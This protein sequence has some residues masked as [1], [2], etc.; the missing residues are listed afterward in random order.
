[1]SEKIS[2]WEKI[3]EPKMY[4][5]LIE[6]GDSKKSINRYQRN[7]WI[8]TIFI[9]LFGLTVGYFVSPWIYFLTIGFSFFVYRSKYTRVIKF[10]RVWKFQR[11]LQ[12]NKFS[13]LLIPYLKKNDGRVSLYSIFNKMLPR[14]DSDADRRILYKLM[15]EMSR[16]PSDVKP[17]IDF[18]NTLSGSDHAVIFMSAIYDFQQTSFDMSVI[19]ELGAIANKQLLNGVDEIIKYKLSKFNMYPT[20]LAMSPM[21]I[22]FGYLIAVLVHEVS[23]MNFNF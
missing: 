3:A 5:L 20:K 6:M 10:Y 1:M 23:K 16:N 14:L 21:I 4:E 19:E 9:L 8:Q 7:R 17:F 18:A 2:F 15:T 22:V 11:N 12:F 13:R